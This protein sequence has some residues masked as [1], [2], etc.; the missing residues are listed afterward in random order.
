[1]SVKNKMMKPEICQSCGLTFTEESKGTNRDHTESEDYCSNC[2]KD[3]IFVE[4]SLSLREMEVRYL[5]MAKMNK[6]LTLE[7]AQETLKILP[8]LKR[9]RIRDSF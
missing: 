9:W 4:P 6:D 5:V 3:G 2:F 8:T 1:M 7:V